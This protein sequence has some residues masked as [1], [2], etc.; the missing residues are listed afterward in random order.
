[1]YDCA[2]FDIDGVLVD[3]RKSYNA[4][5]RKTVA[6]M[7]REF[8]GKTFR[9]LVTDQIIL[10]FRQTGG[11]NNDTD[12]CYAI[13]LAMLAN[14]QKNVMAG[15]KFLANVAENADETGI[16]SVE[17]YLARFGTEKWKRELAYPAPVKDSVLARVFD[18]LF[19]GPELFQRQ[20]HLEPKYSRG[21]RPLI[22]NDRLVVNWQTMKRL[23]TMFSGR[24]AIVSGRS[25]L[26]ADYS[27]GPVMKY[28]H[29]GASVF[30]EDEKREY[31]KPNT[32]AIKHAMAAMNAKTAAYAGDSAEDLLMARRAEKELGGRINFVGI[33]GYSAEPKKTAAGFRK[34]GVV[35]ISSV[36]RLPQ[37]LRFRL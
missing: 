11:F 14:P 37:T 23:H 10:K 20:N 34:E 18:E 13:T 5:I 33:Y 19:Y 15:R 12:T 6:F 25:R 21:T 35:A 29:L 4:A 7:I 32:F 30:L 31:A 27:L 28:F 24:L 17:K 16:A 2:L 26:A 1:M 36:N 9:N 3:I 22:E 8:S